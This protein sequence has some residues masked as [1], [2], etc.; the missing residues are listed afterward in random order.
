MSFVFY[1][2]ET[3]GTD[4][5][6][7]QI[8]QFAAIRTDEDLQE[9]ER[10][11]VRCRL[12]PHVVPSPG[13]MRVTGV[14]VAQLINAELPTHYVMI[15]AIREKLLSWS[16]SLFI[17]YNSVSFDE[18][19]LRQALYQ[20][21]H[22]PYLTNTGGNCRA[23][24]LRMVRAAALFSPN[25]LT[26]PLDDAGAQTFKLERVGPAN[27]FDH[28]NAHDAVGDRPVLSGVRVSTGGDQTDWLG[29]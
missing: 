26:I 22:P 29:M 1:D 15:R 8:L 19:L 10:F 14:S 27:G 20:T 11:D 12:L 5:V 7:D 6:F 17:G 24:A 3:T 21:L 23:D 28:A 13:A 25:A 18:H 4:T 16:P 2:T 9:L